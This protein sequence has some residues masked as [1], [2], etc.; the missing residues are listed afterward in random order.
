VASTVVALALISWSAIMDDF[1]S[2]V[3]CCV[4]IIT[5]V[6]LTLKLSTSL[7]NHRLLQII[8]DSSYALYLIHWPIVCILRFYEFDHFMIRFLAMVLCFGVSVLVFNGYEK[9]YVKLGEQST[10]ILIGGLYLS[11]A[12]VNTLYNINRTGS[13]CNI[14]V[15][16]P[17][18]FAESRAINQCMDTYWTDHVRIPQC[19]THREEGPFGFCNLPPGNG[20]LSVLIIGNSFALNHARLLVDNLK[21]HYGNISLHTEGGCEQLIDT[22]EHKF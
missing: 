12:L 4:T 1:E 2:T 15:H 16:Q 11:M 17:I 21:D 9:W 18:S 5:A 13:R 8:G 7:L 22:T 14:D 10:F 20:N 19:N 3:R 6:I